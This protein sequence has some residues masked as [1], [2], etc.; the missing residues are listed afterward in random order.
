MLRGTRL[1][2]R[3]IDGDAQVARRILIGFFTEIEFRLRC[4]DFG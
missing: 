4:F 2:L 1:K 3:Y